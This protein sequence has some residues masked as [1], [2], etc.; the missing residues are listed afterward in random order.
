MEKLDHTTPS[1]IPGCN[2]E[3]TV[4]RANANKTNTILF[5]RHNKDHSIRLIFMM[6]GYCP[7]A[8]QPGPSILHQ[9][10]S[11]SAMLVWHTDST[12][13]TQAVSL[14]SLRAIPG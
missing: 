5:P 12:K 3:L 13:G 8:P 2:I 11:I 6:M 14:P 7:L 4:S 1:S 9:M 10:G